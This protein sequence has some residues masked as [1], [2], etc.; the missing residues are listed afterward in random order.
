MDE[1]ESKRE[2]RIRAVAHRIWREEGCPHGRDGQHWQMAKDLV[3]I[4]EGYER[5]LKPASE[6]LGPHGEPIEEAKIEE[7][8][9]EFPT[10]TDQGEQQPPR[11]SEDGAG[12]KAVEQP[13]KPAAPK[14]RAP[15]RAKKG[16]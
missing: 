10:L 5:T 1:K 3:A 14:R 6:K 12:E 11:R 15:S 16:A 4:E 13:E 2:D 9:G 7:N 8:L